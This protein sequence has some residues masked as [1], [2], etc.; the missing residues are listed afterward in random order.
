M[1]NYKKWLKEDRNIFFDEKQYGDDGFN[2]MY[3]DLFDKKLRDWHSNELMSSRMKEWLSEEVIVTAENAGEL[4]GEIGML[5]YLM[6]GKLSHSG[7]TE[8]NIDSRLVVMFSHIRADK[9]EEAKSIILEK[10]EPFKK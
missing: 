9:L 7:F 5:R 10:A 4:E 8:D 2:F 1:A 3:L 6:K